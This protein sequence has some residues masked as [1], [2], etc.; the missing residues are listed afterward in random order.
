MTLRLVYVSRSVLPSES[1][2]SVH[3][4]KMA[5]AFARAGHDVTL[6]A[7]SATM[8]PD[9]SALRAAYGVDDSFAL[10]LLARRWFSRTS[11][12][13]L[14]WALART[15]GADVI[16]TRHV[17]MARLAA[18]LGRPCVLELHHPAPASVLARLRRAKRPPLLVAIT[19]ALRTYLLSL[20][21]M[22]GAQI[23]VA[24]DGA[25]PV[26]PNT[27]ASLPAIDSL[28]VGYLGSL[29]PG[30]G[31][32]IA[33]ALA[34]ICP[35]A[36]FAIVGGT[37]SQIA[38]L[39]PQ[40]APNVTFHGHVPHAATAGYLRSFDVAL[41][42]N[43]DFVGTAG[44][45]RLNISAWTSPLKAFEYMAAGLPIIASD[46]PNLREVF[47][48]GHN[49]MLVAPADIAAWASALHQMHATP[50]LRAD[51]GR[52]ALADFAEGYS[53]DARAVA[54]SRAMAEWCGPVLR[55]L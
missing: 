1:A 44:G 24:Q 52:Q 8:M 32:E 29:Y 17:G 13:Y 11:L 30:K 6:L 4:M 45:G 25:D 22:N 21:G 46:Q 9:P 54:L 27:V 10:R 31:A 41:L 36:Q 49:A 5:Q 55:T 43:Q 3:V 40:A 38:S 18:A 14:A 35:F 48:H 26:S 51:L 53:W 12:A 37:P 19:D 47:R 39:R 2:N 28:R 16:Y 33:L 15:R 42:P 20:P 34:P 7:R 23:V 50:S